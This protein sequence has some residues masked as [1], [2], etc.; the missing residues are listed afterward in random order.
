MNR[1]QRRQQ[2]KKIEHI[3]KKSGHRAVNQIA[4]NESP[5]F[6]R[7]PTA[8]MCKSIQLLI[9]ELYHRG[10]RV[11]DFDNKEKYVQGI[12]I[13]RGKVYFLIAKETAEDGE[14]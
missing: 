11:Y 13:I 1:Q 2:S 3:N 9:N 7:V 4:S 8:T 6:S 5:D 10:I 12:Q 14:L